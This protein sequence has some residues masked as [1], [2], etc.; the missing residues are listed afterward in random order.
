MR[1]I[2]I[3]GMLLLFSCEKKTPREQESASCKLP[4]SSYAESPLHPD[5]LKA[6]N[7]FKKEYEQDGL[8]D[9]AIYYYFTFYSYKSDSLVGISFKDCKGDY[10]KSECKGMTNID[11]YYVAVL[12][13]E[14]IGKDFYNSK[15]LIQIDFS[16]LKC[17]QDERE[18]GALSGFAYTIKN[19]RI[20]RFWGDYFNEKRP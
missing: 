7:E 3:I 8:I 18:E 20:A 6:W 17:F 5:L 10:S 15:L 16:V 19:N 9:T 11:G 2:I 4:Y 13:S 14:N 12:D 1:N